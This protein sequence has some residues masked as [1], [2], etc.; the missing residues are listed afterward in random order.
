MGTFKIQGLIHVCVYADERINMFCLLICIWHCCLKIK[1]KKKL[2]RKI[3]SFDRSAFKIVLF[4]LYSVYEINTNTD[5]ENKISLS[6][7]ILLLIAHA[8]QKKSYKAHTERK[9]GFVYIF[10]LFLYHVLL[11]MCAYKIQNKKILEMFI[12]FFLFILRCCLN[13]K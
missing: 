5:T 11:I 13:I 9:N 8:Y 3:V 7:L 6:W 1:Y 12:V 2:H 10:W 4:S